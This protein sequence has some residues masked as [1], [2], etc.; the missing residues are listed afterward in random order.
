MVYDVNDFGIWVYDID[1]AVHIIW[2]AC[3]IVY[4]VLLWFVLVC[5]WCVEIAV[6][7]MFVGVVCL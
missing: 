6:I 1:G 4:L 7:V 5:W 3:F 2:L